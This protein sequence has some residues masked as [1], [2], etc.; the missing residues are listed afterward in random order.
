MGTIVSHQRRPEAIAAD[1]DQALDTLIGFGRETQVRVVSIAD[2]PADARMA[3]LL[4]VAEGSPVIEAVRMRDRGG[5]PLG[6]VTSHAIPELAPIFTAECLLASPLLSLLSQAGHRIGGGRESIGAR[7][8]DEETAAL[9]HLEWRAP[10]LV[11][12]RLV[13]DEDGRPL[14]R[15]VAEYRADHYHIELDLQPGDRA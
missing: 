5:A 3:A 2:V 6:R 14:L 15:T 13:T 8:A 12:E 9:L 4:G 7:P 11:V 1:L 10:L